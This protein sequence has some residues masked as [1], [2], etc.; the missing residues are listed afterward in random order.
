MKTGLLI[1]FIIG[2]FYKKT[3]S[4]DISVITFREIDISSQLAKYVI[5]VKAKNNGNDD[6]SSFIHPISK[7]ENSHLS[8]IFGIEGKDKILQASQ[9]DVPLENPEYIYYKIN[10]NFPLKKSETAEF[11]IEYVLTQSFKL[12]P[13]EIF[14]SESQ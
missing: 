9:L 6:V 3:P 8:Y 14:Q 11:K 13:A 10:L 12:Y 2:I 4:S 5:S 7:E 1:M